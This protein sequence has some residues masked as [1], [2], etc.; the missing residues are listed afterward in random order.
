M[1]LRLCIYYCNEIKTVELFC[2]NGVGSRQCKTC[3]NK[4]IYEYR[5]TPKGILG[6]QKE[7]QN[8]RLNGNHKKRNDS[9]RK[10]HHKK[11]AISQKKLMNHDKD[12]LG[13]TYI[14]RLLCGKSDLRFKDIPNELV[15]LKRAEIMLQR[16]I[17]DA[18]M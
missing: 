8:A 11:I 2:K 15:K 5:K 4:G 13:N 14:K 12:V 6:R 1:L 7:Q 3:F 10:R 9:Y 18:K 17:K 16:G